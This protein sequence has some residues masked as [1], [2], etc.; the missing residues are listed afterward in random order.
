[1]IPCKFVCK[2][3]MFIKITSHAT[4]FAWLHI[5]YGNVS[6][7][8]LKEYVSNSFAIFFSFITW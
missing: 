5:D 1:L 4:F 6:I 3:R 7:D 2:G 8:F